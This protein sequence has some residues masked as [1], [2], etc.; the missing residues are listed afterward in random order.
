M[1]KTLSIILLSLLAGCEKQTDT[2]L[3]QEAK[4]LSFKC[5]KKIPEFT[6]GPYSDPSKEKI[7]TLCACIWNN[8]DGWEKETSIEIAEGRENDISAMHMRAFPSRFG[9]VMEACGAS[10]L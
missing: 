6:L 5:E 8:L 10:S 3:A 9:G 4:N 7:D 2:A 1:K